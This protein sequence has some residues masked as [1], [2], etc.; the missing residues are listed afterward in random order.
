MLLSF[1]LV[2]GAALAEVGL[3]VVE[4]SAGG[5]AIAPADLIP[6]P[7]LGLRFAPFGAGCD[8][9]GFR[10]PVALRQADIVTLGDSQTWGVNARMTETWPM[11]LAT[12]TGR[13]VYNMGV[14]GFGSVQYYALVEDAIELRPRLIVVALYLGN[15]LYDTYKAVYSLPAWVTLRSSALPEL[16]TDTVQPRA[17]SEWNTEKAFH[18]SYG[19]SQPWNW[20]LWLRGH[21]AIGRRLDR[22][23]AFGEDAWFAI[24]RAWAL[25]HPES[26]GFYDDGTVRTVFTVGYRLLAVDLA[27]PRIQEGLRLTSGL[28]RDMAA[29]T[30]RAGVELLV[31]LVPTKERAFARALQQRSALTRAHAQLVRNEDDC[32]DALRRVAAE[33]Q[34]P[35]LDLLGPLEQAIAQGRQVYPT[36]IESH[37]APDGY[38]IVARSVAGWLRHVDDGLRGGKRA[39]P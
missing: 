32:R 27:E 23:G 5:G 38:D 21:T 12:L 9:R 8:A 25:D 13:T 24:G 20:G 2:T 15:D 14:G 31:M 37:P 4:Q 1:G 35:V 36:N 22:L 39:N 16:M 33:S 30:H 28:L 11:R 18:R 6:D 7:R 29:E 19:R 34:I 17:D 10:N 26:G 3:R